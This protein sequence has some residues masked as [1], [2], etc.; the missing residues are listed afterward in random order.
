MMRSEIVLCT[1]NRAVDVESL[2]AGLS[3]QS[4]TP[5]LLVVDA[6]DDDATRRVL[7][8]FAASGAWPAVRHRHAPPGLARQRMAGVRALR[9]DTEVVH[10]ID[11]DVQLAPDYFAQIERVFVEHDDV[12][13]VGGWVINTPS[14]RVR[15]TGPMFLLDS[16]TRQ[17]RVLPSGANV[18]VHRPRG[19]LDV[20]WLSGC[21]MAYRRRVFAQLS[22]D[23]RMTGYSLGEDVDFSFRVSRL[24]RV[25]VTERA[26]LRHL[27]SEVGRWDHARLARENARRRHAFVCELRGHGV[28]RGA[29]WW[30]LLGEILTRAVRGVLRTDGDERAVARAL[31][32]G[33]ADILRAGDL[34]ANPRL[35]L[36]L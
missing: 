21:A 35:H 30:S 31:L 28:N 7:D 19:I 27:C 1:R 24:G 4:V 9:D 14:R 34:P 12:L 29:F 3:G 16:A 26:R 25:V 33:T 36:G 15:F 10:F 8:A 6:S 13:G 22:F 20:D 2:L 18:L 11:D 5:A 32:R 23:E 17:G